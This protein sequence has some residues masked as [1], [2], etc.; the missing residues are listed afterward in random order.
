M[1]ITQIQSL[2][3][4]AVVMVVIFHAKFFGG[5]FL[6][7]GFVG[8]DIFYVI[9]GY[10]ITGLILKELEKENSFSFSA[11][12]IRR[13]K[14][15]L[16]A[17]FLILIITGLI[18]WLVL[19]TILRQELGRDIVAASLYISNYL[20]AWWQNDY[21]NLSATPPVVIHFWSLAVEEQFY[22]FWPI[23]IFALYKLGKRR[24]VLFGIG[25]ISALSLALSI[26]L[27]PRS[28]I[29]SFY[30]LPT[31]AW[32][33]GIGALLLFIPANKR[34]HSSLTWAGFIALIISSLIFTD[35]TPFPGYI[36]LLPVLGTAA[37]L[38]TVRSWP[39][40]LNVTGN[41]SVVQWLG[42]IS[43]PLY[44]WHW[45][46]LV[47]PASYLGRPLRTYERILCIVLTIILADLTHRF[48]E[49]PIRQ[50]KILA[51]K[52]VAMAIIATATS[53]LLGVVIYSTYSDKATVKGLPQ[54]SLAQVQEKPIIYNDG[55]HVN[56]G[57]KISPACTYGDIA[58]SKTIVLFG[59]SHAAQWFPALELLALQKHFKLISLTKS[60]C[61]AADVSRTTSG[62][63]NDGECRMWRY[64]SIA[65]INKLKPAAVIV[66]GYQSYRV[67]GP[68]Q[69]IW[70]LAGQGRTYAA[71]KG[72]SNALI[73]ISDTPRP[74]RDIPLCLSAGNLSQCNSMVK[75]DPHVAP[76]YIPVNPTPW[77][78]S[79]TCPAIVNSHVAYRDASHISVWT[80]KELS[81]HILVELTRLGVLK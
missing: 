20:F 67:A 47:L 34:F 76:G 29:W 56:Y 9:S 25:I 70:W 7:G 49:E 19:P 58:S 44:L 35:G 71:L 16:P 57:I 36:A 2:R 79:A 65:R 11:F 64:N 75:M 12:Y 1:R 81:P 77:L 54:F 17:S 22:L 33:L 63:Y 61:P 24:L 13:I 37:M 68:D 30:S 21:Q 3:A 10:L 62:S 15:L 78:C 14:R 28:P 45:P 59:D 32:E 69:K 31:R 41:L 18:S 8:V 6:G 51:K 52:V 60:S 72:A 4:L 50:K 74:A 26:F 80:S 46:A 43:Y 23:V 42:A 73:Y 27:T 40:L 53:A 66:S 39:P 38:A 55:C 48:L 5:S